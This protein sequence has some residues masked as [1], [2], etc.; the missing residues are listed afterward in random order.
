MKDLF[1]RAVNMVQKGLLGDIKKDHR[2]HQ[3]P[4]DVG[5][6]FPKLAPPKELDWN[7]WLGQAPKVDYIKERCH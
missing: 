4:A 7:F 2:G 1:L 5:G 6:P 3:R